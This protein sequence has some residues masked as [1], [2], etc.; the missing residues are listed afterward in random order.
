LRLFGTAASAAFRAGIVG[1]G[2][3]ASRGAAEPTAEVVRQTSSSL[4]LLPL[5]GWSMLLCHGLING[6]ELGNGSAQVFCHVH[7][8]VACVVVGAV[9]IAHGDRIWVEVPEMQRSP[10]RGHFLVPPALAARRTH[11]RGFRM[12]EVVHLAAPR[13]N[14]HAIVAVSWRYFS[15]IDLFNALSDAVVVKIFDGNCR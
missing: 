5:G 12:P 2:G 10:P 9:G 4:K 11:V 3:L 6:H 1:V 7:F 14:H 15:K 8:R 13:R